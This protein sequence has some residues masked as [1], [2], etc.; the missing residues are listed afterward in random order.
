MKPPQWGAEDDYCERFDRTTGG[1]LAELLSQPW[2]Q[3]GTWQ[4][5]AMRSAVGPKDDYFAKCLNQNEVCKRDP[6]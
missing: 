4:E 3:E 2:S 5:L 1:G 6:L